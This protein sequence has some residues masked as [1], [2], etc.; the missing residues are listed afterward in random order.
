M[1]PGGGVK[2]GEGRPNT[3]LNSDVPPMQQRYSGFWLDCETGWD[4]NPSRSFLYKKMPQFQRNYSQM[5]IRT[6]G[7]S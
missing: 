2:Q 1:E 6:P 3:H 7:V 4:W 5:S